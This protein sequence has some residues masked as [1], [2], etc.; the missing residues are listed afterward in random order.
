MGGRRLHQ[1]HLHRSR[2]LEG[3][4]NLGMFA[5]LDP[6]SGTHVNLDLHLN[7]EGATVILASPVRSHA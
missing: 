5:A 3:W 4:K 2:Q 1:G 7:R 6:A